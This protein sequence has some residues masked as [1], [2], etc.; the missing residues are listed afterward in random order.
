MTSDDLRTILQKVHA[1]KY[2][3]VNVNTHLRRS[4]TNSTFEADTSITLEKDGEQVVVNTSEPDCIRYAFELRSIAECDGEVLLARIKRPAQY[5]QSIEFLVSEDKAKLKNAWDE[6]SSGKFTFRYDPLG[7]IGELLESRPTRGTLR[8][9]RFLPLRE[10][11]F[12]VLALILRQSQESVQ[13]Q[14]EIEERLPEA[15]ELLTAIGWMYA[16]FSFVTRNPI[17]NYRYFKRHVSFDSDMLFDQL[18]HQMEITN[19][20]MELLIAG[21]KLNPRIDI[22]KMMDVYSRCI[23]PLTP[24]INLLRVGLQLRE[25]VPSPQKKLNLARNIAVLKAHDK[26]GPLFSCLDEQIRHGDAHTSTFIRGNQVEIRNGLTR[27]SRII[28]TF[29]CLELANMI[30]E[31]KQQF[32][33]ALLISTVLNDFAVCSQQQ[34][35]RWAS[36]VA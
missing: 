8:N 4:D 30:L 18:F 27:K 6:L 28:R 26:Y 35:G 21:G 7:L 24:L 32:F 33:P 12:H 3:V 17:K 16:A 20:A 36:V 15:R 5:D 11:Y 34:W 31:M 13:V 22:P 2:K 23:E 10:D 25:G 1:D 19:E 14:N 9:P 29:P